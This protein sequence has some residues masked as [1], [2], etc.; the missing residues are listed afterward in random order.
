MSSDN[1]HGKPQDNP[2]QGKP[3]ENPGHGN[4]RP[5]QPPKPPKRP[6]G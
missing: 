6:V 1:N 3:P 5:D 4:G 2:G